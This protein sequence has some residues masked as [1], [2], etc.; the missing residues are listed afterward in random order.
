M[1]IVKFNEVL[2]AY[3]L[4]DFDG[5]VDTRAF[6]SLQRGTVHIVSH[7]LEQEGEPPEDIDGGDYLALPDKA[8]L[9]LGRSLAIE[10]TQEQLPGDIDTVWEYFRKRGAYGHFKHLLE[11]KGRLQAWYDYENAAKQDRLSAW[12]ADHGIGLT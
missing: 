9:C 5:L 4:S 11:R 3:E 6:I 10:F 7:D 8:E 12:C 2:D 1:T